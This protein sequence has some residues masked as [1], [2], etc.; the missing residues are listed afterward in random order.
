MHVD[1]LYV[2][3]KGELVNLKTFPASVDSP[4]MHHKALHA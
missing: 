4:F 2:S 1:P 3:H